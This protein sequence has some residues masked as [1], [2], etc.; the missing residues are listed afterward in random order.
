MRFVPVLQLKKTSVWIMPSAFALKCLV[1]LVFL[2]LYTYYYG[3][4]TLSQDA[5]AFFHESQL[6]NN[7]FFQSPGDYF[8][9]IFDQDPNE[10]L[11]FKYLG[12]TEH[13]QVG[14][15][16]FINDSKNLIK[17]HSVIHFMSAGQVTIHM[18][19]MSMI[20]LLGIK[21]M[22]E[23]IHWRTSFSKLFVFCALLL[24]PGLLFWSSGILKESF[25]VLG[26]GFLLRSFLGELS[27]QKR[28]F[29]L[30]F[31][32]LILLLF[33]TSL[34]IPI[35]PVLLFLL[36]YRFAPKFKLASGFF[37]LTV[38]AIIMAVS[39]PSL[40]EQSVHYLS[41]KQF[42]FNN[43]A[44]GGLHADTDSNF[45]YFRPDQIADL[46][47]IG[48]S[49][50][51]TKPTKALILLHGQISDPVPIQLVPNG[52]K[53]AIYFQNEECRGY[54]P[55]SPINDSFKQLLINIP[56]ALSNALLRPFP[57]DK[58][59]VLK[60]PAMFEMWLFILVLGFAIWQRGIITFE[61]KK[62]VVALVIFCLVLS[63]LI[64]WVT[65]V[66]GAIVRYRLPVQL[67]MLIISLLIIR[68]FSIKYIY[69]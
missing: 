12:K 2:Y 29:D 30:I 7:V 55:L 36:I 40:R 42:D 16:T 33:K 53:W 19:I 1:G 68:K 34:V 66:F 23:A 20:S 38:I 10:E 52:D 58:G 14:K 32:F 44:R 63:L 43:I 8:K 61:T 17:F 51:L 45:Y 4:G 35:L 22:T 21:Q 31:G 25:M 3:E 24:F 49:V 50:E 54:K 48:D 9:L 6:L 15:Q 57:T 11:L 28:I 59:G 46:N 18:M 39:M 56:E 62:I 41:R 13:W 65:P 67:A 37:G 5:G 27:S 64:G 47:L 60:F 26:I 69:E